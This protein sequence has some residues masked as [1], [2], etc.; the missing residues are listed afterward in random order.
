MISAD[1]YFDGKAPDEKVHIFTRRHWLFLLPDIIVTFGLVLL[2]AIIVIIAAALGG[3]PFDDSG[4]T[5]LVT[6][7]PAYYLAV[8]TWFFIRWL[9]YYLDLSI[10]TDQRVVDIDQF[11]LFRRKISELQLDAVQDVSSSRKGIFQTMFNYGDLEI[12]T[13]AE[14]ENF[15]FSSVPRP[16]T[17]VQTILKVCKDGGGAA[18][19]ADS[20]EQMHEAAEAMKQAAEQMQHPA[21]NAAPAAD[22]PPPPPSTP[23][24]PPAKPAPASPPPQTEPPEQELPREPE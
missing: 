11:G 4:R 22:P 8:L 5:I 9:D 15:E 13:A 24:P 17:M 19:T 6:I 2:P 16:D 12:Q 18:A 3:S 20:A 1:P 21:S 14:R 23:S 7:V 10:V